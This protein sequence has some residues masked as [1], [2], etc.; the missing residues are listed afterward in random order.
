MAFDVSN[1]YLNTPMTRYKYVKMR[2]ADIPDEVVKEYKL[3]ENEK[4]TDDGFV[5][6]EVRKDMY[7]LPQAGIL[8]QQLLETRLNERVY[9][10][11]T[12][13]PGLWKHKW[14]PVQFTLVVDDFGVKYVGEEHAQHLIDT[15]RAHY[16]LEEDWKG[17]KYIGIQLN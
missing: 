3:Q 13:V 6:V 1:F 16:D 2:L 7:G 9:Y 8:A 17:K 12:I 4:V 15:V 10:R 14:R 5:Y 11:S